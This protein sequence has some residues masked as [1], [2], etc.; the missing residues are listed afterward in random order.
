MKTFRLKPEASDKIKALKNATGQTEAEI[1]EKL[2]AGWD[3]KHNPLISVNFRKTLAENFTF[4]VRSKL[5][6][7][8]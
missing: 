4:R 7:L 6:K 1:I 5:L 3:L 8:F 2:V